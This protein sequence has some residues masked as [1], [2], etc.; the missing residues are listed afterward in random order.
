MARILGHYSISGTTGA[1]AA[2]AATRLTWYCRNTDASKL[3]LVEGITIDGVIA[4]TAFAV[5]Q[6]LYQLNVARAFTAE[7]GAPGGTALTITGNNQKLRTF[8][9]TT[10]AAVVRIASTASLAAPT[11]TLDSNSIGQLNSHSSAGVFA[12]APIL[13]QQY[14]PRDGLLYGAPDDC[15]IV[16]AT[17]E[18]L[19]IQITVPATGVW[20]AGITMNWTETAVT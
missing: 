2:G 13:G 3:M 11:W 20:T 18:G 17:N 15:P 8:D 12:A 1:M 14:L 4:T 9:D 19:G 10:I 7:N 16:L 5:G 6:V